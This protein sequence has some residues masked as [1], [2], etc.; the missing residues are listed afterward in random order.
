MNEIEQAAAFL[1]ELSG[2]RALVVTHKNADPDAIGCA[3]TVKKVCD[4][5]GVKAEVHLPDG[6]SKVSRSILE[7]LGVS[8][9]EKW[10]EAQALIVCDTSNM[11][12]IGDHPNLIE[13][14]PE[15]LVIDHHFPPGSLAERASVRLIMQEPAS[16]V[17]AVL[18]A[19]RLG[20]KLD[21][22][23]ATLALAGIIY[24]TRRFLYTSPNTFLASKLLLESGVDYIKTLKMLE[25]KEDYSEIIARLKGVQR[26]SIVDVC[27]YL[28]AITESSAYEASVAR[29]LV[30]LG[31]DLAIVV[32]G[33]GVSR[34]SV[35]VS[36]RLLRKGF[37][38]SSLVADVARAIGGEAGGH[39]GASGYMR[40]IA[41]REVK[42][43]KNKTLRQLLLR[44]ID[45]L[46]GFCE[47]KA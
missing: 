45:S 30:S 4:S 34:A 20:V 5:L 10:G 44:A 24:D 36:E 27:G 42:S 38:S 23:T 22:V 1:R 35:R 25:E 3:Y 21:S 2:K 18:L 19:E 29:T 40:S 33:H 13:G 14:I 32:G 26:A 16:T 6:P 11:S 28:V 15:V 39:P 12:M 41:R 9:Q 47:E 37:D 7:S 8:W 17:I 46:M 31:V 43:F